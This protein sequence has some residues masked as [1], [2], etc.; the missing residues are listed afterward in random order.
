MDYWASTSEWQLFKQMKHCD[1][2][3]LFSLM[4]LL[5]AKFGP[6][7]SAARNPHQTVISCECICFPTITCGLLKSQMH[8]QLIT[9]W[10]G[11]WAADIIGAYF[12]KNQYGQVRTVTSARYCNIQYFIKYNN[13]WN[14]SD[15]LKYIYSRS[16]RRQ[17]TTKF[18]KWSVKPKQASWF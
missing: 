2:E 9:V 17:N 16:A 18:E 14:M 5:I 8:S 13:F 12:Y 6:M 3:H 4:V 11:F 15:P 7:M 1:E 10:S